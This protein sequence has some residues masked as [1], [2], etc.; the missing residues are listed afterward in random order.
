MD[1]EISI[2]IEIT[3]NLDVLEAAQSLLSLLREKRP[4]DRSERDR[5]FAI[6]ITEAEKLEAWIAWTLSTASVPE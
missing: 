2:G 1:N 5:R 4:A 6:A 3:E